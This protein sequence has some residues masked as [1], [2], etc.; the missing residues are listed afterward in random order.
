FADFLPK[1]NVRG[2]IRGYVNIK[3]PNV[4]IPWDTHK[5]HLNTDREVIEL[6]LTHPTIRNLFENWKEAFNGISALPKG[7]ITKA[8]SER[9]PLL[10]DPKTGDLAIE[11]KSEVKIDRTKKRGQK[12]PPSVPRPKVGVARQKK[13][14]GIKLNMVLATEDARQLAT[15]LVVEGN[16]ED[17]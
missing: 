6:L 14:G 5:R 7:E 10:V 3:G 15:K 17:P 2:Y 8:V 16:V 9:Y 4:F 1:S 12:L 11:Q 13:N